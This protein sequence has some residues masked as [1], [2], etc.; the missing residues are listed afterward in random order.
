MT[1]KLVA[2]CGLF[3]LIAPAMTRAEPSRCAPRDTVVAQLTERYGESRQVMGLNP[4][5]TM[6]ELYASA[7]TGSW[8]ITVT[9]P[10]GTTCVVAVG[11]AYEPVAEAL[12]P[13]GL[14]L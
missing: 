14:P 10:N 5:N 2:V 4:N 3:S 9:A 12:R 11:Q 13:A 7:E 6:M 1:A 8:T